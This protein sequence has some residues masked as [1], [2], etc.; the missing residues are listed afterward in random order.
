M[1]EDL[2]LELVNGEFQN[3]FGTAV[4]VSGDWMVVSARA[5]N[6]QGL[7][8]SG[9]IYFYHR[10]PSGWTW[11]QAFSPAD[12]VPSMTLG[13]G[14]VIDGDRVAVNATNNPNGVVYILENHSGIWEQVAR[15][16]DRPDYAY[17]FGGRLALSGNTLFAGAFYADYA[18]PHWGAVY[19][20][21]RQPNGDWDL[22]QLILPPPNPPGVTSSPHFGEAVAISGDWAAVGMAGHQQIVLPGGG[23]GYLEDRVFVYQRVGGNGSWPRRLRIQTRSI[24]VTPMR[25]SALRWPCTVGPLLWG[26]LDSKI[27]MGFP[28]VK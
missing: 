1:T 12:A 19:V 9:E 17:A 28:G 3:F 24:R 6:A 15:L 13:W 8:N 22:S 21:D 4:A 25:I 16:E 18:G 11:T 14:V 10:G 2:R 27:P 5:V 23:I 7:V 26:L 20:Y